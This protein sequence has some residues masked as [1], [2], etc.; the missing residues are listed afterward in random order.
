MS[1]SVF[2][3]LLSLFITV[4][5]FL[6]LFVGCDAR[7]TAASPQVQE[8]QQGVVT[9][10]YDGDTIRVKLEGGESEIV[11]FIGVNAPELAERRKEVRFLALMSKRFAFYHLYRER[12]RLVF[13]WERRDK[14]DRL[15]A[16]VFTE[17]GFFNEFILREGF[18]SVFLKY[19]F[20]A[21]FKRRLET[22]AKDARREGRGFWQ[23]EPYPVISAREAQQN[24]GKLLSVRFQCAE[25]KSEGK[26]LFLH[27]EKGGFSALMEKANATALPKPPEG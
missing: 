24:V 27:A 18:A 23:A 1:L 12:V 17:K 22:A 9:A 7:E 19:P 6:F 11:R 14:Y 15:L 20:R 26:F 25:V 13:D 5:L 10:V 3:Y 8:E 16:F 4:T 2:K 21:D